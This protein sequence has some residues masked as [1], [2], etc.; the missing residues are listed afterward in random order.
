MNGNCDA[1]QPIL[2]DEEIDCGAR[3]ERGASAARRA[4]SEV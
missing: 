4:Q 3:P 2:M 1:L